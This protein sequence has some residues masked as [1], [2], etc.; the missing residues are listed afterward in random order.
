M[1][2]GELRLPPTIHV[3]LAHVAADAFSQE[4]RGRGLDV[5]A[6]LGGPLGDP[7]PETSRRWR[8]Y[9]S[10]RTSDPLDRLADPGRR[11]G[12]LACAAR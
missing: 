7:R 8:H 12:G 3:G 11:R 1:R 6:E 10:D 9:P 2:L 4:V 5:D